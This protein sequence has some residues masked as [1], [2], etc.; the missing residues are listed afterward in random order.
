MVTFKHETLRSKMEERRGGNARIKHK[1]DR[2]VSLPCLVVSLCSE[3]CR[4]IC[5]GVPL[6]Q[7]GGRSTAKVTKPPKNHAARS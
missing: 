5:Q 2:A 6:R 1:E 7:T 3:T 4:R